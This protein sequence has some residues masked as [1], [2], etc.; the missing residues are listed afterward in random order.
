MFPGA[1]AAY[2]F[3]LD[4]VRTLAR[5]DKGTTNNDYSND[6]MARAQYLKSIGWS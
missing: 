5:L 4:D 3:G 2:N 6:V 1:V